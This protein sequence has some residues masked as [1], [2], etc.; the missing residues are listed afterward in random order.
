VES[1][2]TDVV[3]WPAVKVV[4]KRVVIRLAGNVLLL[5]AINLAVKIASSHIKIA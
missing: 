4:W 5:N 2:V 1:I 3:L